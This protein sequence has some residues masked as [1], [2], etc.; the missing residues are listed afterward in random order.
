MEFRLF[1]E[2][3]LHAGGRVLDLGTP[4]QQ[5]VLAALVVDA[6]RPVSIETLIDR[7]W[8]DK[9][10][11]EARNVLYSHL[12]RIR[13]LLARAVD[14]NSPAVISRRTT[15]YILEMDPETVDLHRF[16]RLIHKGKD[17]RNTDANRVAALAEAL[18]MWRGPP[19]AAVSGAWADQVRAAW[20]WQRLDAA[21][22]W[23]GLELKLGRSAAVI[24]TLPDLIDE[25]PLAEPLEALLMRALHAAGRGAEAVDRYTLVRKRFADQLG[26]D[27]G[28]ELRAVH[29]AI[30]RGERTSAPVSAPIA[31]TP[32]QL[33][34]DTP[35]FAG[36]GAE[37]RYL[38]RVLAGPSTTARIVVL[39]GTAGVGKTTTAVHWAQIVRDRFPD[40]QLY[41]NLRGF[42]PTG[43]PVTPVEAVRGFLEA[44]Q[45]SRDRIPTTLEAQ[46]GLY[47]S[48][49]ANRRVLVLFDNAHDAEQVRALL[50]GSPGNLALVTSRDRLDGLIVLGAHPIPVGLLDEAEAHAV[51]RTRLG[52]ERIAAE[53]ESVDEIIGLCARLPLAL[54]VVAARAATH[55]GFGL[56][57]LAEQLRDARGGLDEFAGGD[58]ATDPRAVF[59]WSYLQLNPPTARLFRLLGLHP[60]PDIGFRAVA[61]LAGLPA[62]KVRPML[63]ELAQVHLITEHS[64]AR[65]TCHDLLRAYA[66][67]LSDVDESLA[68]RAQAIRR[69][70]GHYAHTAYIADGFLDPRREVPPTLSPLPDGA[71]P[72]RIVDHGKALAWFK[73]EHRVL[74]MALHQDPEF[75]AQVWELAWSIR[76][77]L[78]MQGRWHDQRDAYTVALAA[79][80]RL[81]DPLKLAF[82]HCYIGCAFVWLGQFDEA[83]NELHVALNLYETV[84]D[85]IGQAHVHHQFAWL[86]DKQANT[87]EALAHAER[88]LE[89]FRVAGHQ[90]GQARELNSV[91][92]FHALLGR[93]AVAVEYCQEAL[94][95]QLR[96]GDHL[97]AVQTWDSLGYAHAQMG[98]KARAIA[99]YERALELCQRNEALIEVAHTLIRLA[100]IRR[101]TGD[102]ESARVEWQRAHDIL[103]QLGH[104]DAG[105]VLD[106]LN[107]YTVGSN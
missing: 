100:D 8:G 44:F 30:L 53:L 97:N 88:A 54:A 2:V 34:P 29:S 37:L 102:L 107:K 41:V 72:E 20:H 76:R 103:E 56:A 69:M 55:P 26:A 60:G 1:G 4:R 58:P 10:P 27:P 17:V 7:V 42:D 74:L 51:L 12:S 93:Y 15:G 104:P 87:A 36:R 89:F 47:R 38:D 78:G 64:P 45:V 61:S 40:G 21:V 28:P 57:A 68:D 18:R 62:S 90:A 39:S 59:S 95:I 23:A 50:P 16:T 96:L 5:A 84:G 66:A 92:W 85:V 82:V 46:V 32:A 70:L 91:G 6:G 106:K 52:P 3:H 105:E 24:G 43:S 48:L 22:E 83:R 9:P 94:E 71:E 101:D 19:L 35:G 81:G 13:R 98:D 75:D 67:E 86:L 31:A 80:R 77:F 25:Y 99:C 63:A 65:Y 33:P 11:A 49:L 79:A 14:T 73:A